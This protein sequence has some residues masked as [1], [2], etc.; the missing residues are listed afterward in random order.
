MYSSELRHNQVFLTSRFTSSIFQLKRLLKDLIDPLEKQINQQND[1]GESMA[2]QATIETFYS[3]TIKIFALL[4]WK[5]L[6]P[7]VHNGNL[8]PDDDTD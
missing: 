8:C 7:K 3:V 2:V 6:L 4:L 5:K 1:E